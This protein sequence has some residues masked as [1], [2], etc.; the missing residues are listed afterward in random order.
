MRNKYII[1]ALIMMFAQIEFLSANDSFADAV[2]LT[3]SR[4][5]L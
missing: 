1:F 3:C 5:P 4:F 2:K